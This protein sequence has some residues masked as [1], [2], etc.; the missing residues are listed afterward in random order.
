MNNS[1][2]KKY[3]AKLH[4]EKRELSLIRKKNNDFARDN[5]TVSQSYFIRVTLG[6]STP[7]VVRPDMRDYEKLPLPQ[8]MTEEMVADCI[9]HLTNRMNEQGHTMVWQQSL[10]ELFREKSLN[11]E[12]AA[13]A[14]VQWT[15]Y[16]DNRKTLAKAIDFDE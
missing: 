7:N 5:F 11:G 15:Q 4:N 9:E 8:G 1:Q 3:R 14:F 6:N 12:Q 16:I 10:D 13:Y 2:A